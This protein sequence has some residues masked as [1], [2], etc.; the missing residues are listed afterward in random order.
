MLPH[1]TKLKS[2]DESKRRHLAWRLDQKT[3]CGLISACQIA[4]LETDDRDK[5][6]FRIFMAMG[7]SERRAKIHARKVLNFDS[8]IN[9]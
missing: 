2:L 5:E 8:N 3:Y 1:S 6:V 7:M 9:Y 4:R